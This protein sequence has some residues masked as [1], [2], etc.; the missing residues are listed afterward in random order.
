MKNR[1]YVL[2]RSP[3]KKNEDKLP[4]TVCKKR[5]LNMTSGKKE[6]EKVMKD[7]DE[8]MPEKE[9]DNMEENGAE[10]KKGQDM[11]EQ[12]QQPT[13]SLE[14]AKLQQLQGDTVFAEGAVGNSAGVEVSVNLKDSEQNFLKT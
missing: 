2:K 14:G 9:E 8:E 1:D 12:D 6:G 5:R 3:I 13:P 11:K 4:E 7:G 10:T